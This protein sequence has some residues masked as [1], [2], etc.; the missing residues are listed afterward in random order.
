MRKWFWVLALAAIAAA[1]L[2][3]ACGDDEEET[4]DN[5]SPGNNEE[6]GQTVEMEMDDFYFDPAELDAA[7]GDTITVNLKN[8]GQATHTF[9]IDALGIDQQVAAGEEATVQVH[10]AEAGDLRFYCRFH[11]ASGMEGTIK[12][13]SG[14]AGAAPGNPTT[15]AGSGGY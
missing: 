11:G 4:G 2:A 10:A 14:S 8:E 15:S 5:E 9:T 6:A 1:L 3:A 7:P 13:G 12:V